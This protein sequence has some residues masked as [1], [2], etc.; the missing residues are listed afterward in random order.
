MKYHTTNNAP[1][2][3]TRGPMMTP[4]EKRLMLDASLP[5]LTGAVL[6][7]D[8]ADKTT[9]KDGDGDNAATGTGGANN[10]F[11]GSVATW[12]DKSGA[13][14]NLTNT[15]A[16][17]QPTYA[18][19]LNG[20]SVITFDGTND[21]LSNSG[22]VISGANYTTF[23]VFERTNTGTVRNAVYEL[24][25]TGTRNAIYYNN[26]ANKQSYYLNSIF[27]NY[28][29]NY[30][31]GNY[32]ILNISQSGTAYTGRVNGTL[33]L[34]GTG[35]TRATTTGIYLA[36]DS[37]GGDA[38]QGRVAE[39]IVYNR[40]LTADERHDVETYLAGKWGLT[41]PDTAPTVSTNTGATVNQGS[42]I[43]IG[44]ALLASTDIDNSESSLNYKITSLTTH[45]TLT[46]I[47]TAHTYTLGESFTQADIDAGYIKYTHD[48][49]TNFTDSFTFTV[50]D[51]YLSTTSNTFSFTVTPSNHA[52]QFQGWTLVSSENFESGAT[53]WSNTLTE[54]GGT[55]LTNFLGRHSQEAGV[56]S[57]YKTYTM[58]GTQDYTVITF[59]MYKIDSWDGESFKIFVND[60]VVFN[61]ALNQSTFA[62]PVDGVSGAV[63]YTV[64]DTTPY[65]ANFAFASYNDQI[66]HFTLTISNAAAANLKLG[67]S[68]T[69]DQAT[70][71]ESWGVDNINIYEVKTGGSPGPYSIVE[72]AP[73]G[74]VV[75]A[76]TAKDQDVGDVL[77]YS[78]VGGTGVGVFNLNSS[79]GVITVANSSAL[80][81]ES[82]TSYTLDIKVTDNGTPAMSSTKTI[83][84]NVTDMPENTAPTIAALGPLTVAENAANNTVIGTAIGSD[85]DGNTITYSITG[86]NTDN[87]FA[88]NAA[89][90]A[91]RISSNT[92]LNYDF[93]N[94]YTLTI[95]ATD[96]GFGSLV[97]TRNVVVNITDVNEAPTFNIPQSFLDQNPYLR[98]N[99]ATGNFYQY[100]ATT[101][102]YTAAT[103]AAAAATLNGVAGHL[104]TITSA[105]ENAYVRALGSGVLWLGGSDS[106]TEGIWIWA[107][108]GVEGG[109]VFSNVSTSQ[110]GYYT[111]WAAGQP[112]NSSNEDHLEMSAA[113]TWND[114]LL[115]VAKSYVIEWE[116]AAVMAALG[117]GP[118]T[119]AE[120]PVL[121]Q[122]V[123]SVHARDQDAGDTLTYSITGG[124]GSSYFAIDSSTGEITVTNP[125]ALDYET[126]TSYTL[127]T[128]VQDAGGLFSTQSVTIN[129]TD[130]NEA[131]VLDVNAGITL[132]EGASKVITNTMLSSSDVDASPDSALI[133]TVTDATD[134][135]I[136]FNTNTNA[137][138]ALNSTF[139]QGDVDNGY[140]RYIHNDGETTSDSFQFTVSDGLITL[141]SATFSII[142]TPVN[143]GPSFD[144]IQ[145]LL[146]A[147]A[148]LHYNAATGNFYKYVPFSTDYA[149]ATANANAMAL[150]GVGGYLA[151][152]NSA[153]E[154]A[155]LMSLIGGSVWLG[156]SDSDVE[157]TWVY[158]GGAEDGT[159][160][161]QGTSGGSA[162]N[163]N[164]TNWTAGEPNDYS[165]SEDSVQLLGNGEWN[166]INAGANSP[167]IVEWD[168]ASVLAGTTNGPYTINESSAINATVGTVLAYDYDVGDHLTYSIMGGSGAGV[169]S[170]NASTGEI[171]LVSPVNYEV[172][173][174]YTLDLRVQDS[175]GLFDTISIIIDINDVNDAPDNLLL[176]GPHN[177]TE[178][179]AIG[180]SVGFLT[181][182]DEDPAD[183]H[184]YTI[185]TN[186]GGKFMLVGDELQTAAAIDYEQNQSFTIVIRTDDGHGGTLDKSFI[187][188]VNDEPD[189]A[190]SPPT[191]NPNGSVNTYIAPEKESAPDINTITASFRNN[192]DEFSNFYSQQIL[193]ENLTFKLRDILQS[194]E[195]IDHRLE[196]DIEN[197]LM[198]RMFVTDSYLDTP[199]DIS[200]NRSSFTNLR[201]ALSF[202][203]QVADS[204]D[205]THDKVDE[206]HKAR[207]AALPM[208]TIDR[209]FVDVMTYHQER[210]AKL[211]AALMRK[212]G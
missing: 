142:V 181:T 159:A 73:N 156:G 131:P 163:G 183:T 89:T 161:W 70:S 169:F 63:S 199:Q 144:A 13:G 116:G 129:I 48:N 75:G 2:P 189:T 94:T 151:H 202:L 111:N 121:N 108:D 28:T 101:A 185:V 184:I 60:S 195:Q 180:T 57:T 211:R 135:G 6:W 81:Y 179:V 10:G 103:T 206:T 190:T 105:A 203:Q 42:N 210:A 14:N 95:A 148:S 84:I 147:D 191:A 77:A 118:F 152:S 68:S 41:V 127:T 76:I 64:T 16:S 193:R 132:N 97:G 188:N 61:V 11:S 37:T 3:K 212:E 25:G 126:A 165:S 50:N 51:A 174:S 9:V 62:S 30:V 170:V 46:N 69:L 31:P 149:T 8:A 133:Y 187:I 175:G 106:V 54:N 32:E 12:V 153:A 83:T 130:V 93:R 44:S 4:L 18:N 27:Y 204:A 117:N 78:I 120:N 166:D 49:S 141:P 109:A 21:V 98:Y 86:G 194:G 146:N 168:G 34:S 56:Q 209:Q 136:L 80:N 139:T 38:M 91:I 100:V 53:G 171:K 172:I 150:N 90:G 145:A 112:D 119:I 154:N 19:T 85:V 122:V 40:V 110:N 158:V 128:R 96:N 178:N 115:T 137:S 201:E 138:L 186:P 192:D 102:N 20:N 157:G 198:D 207:L 66:M 177:V 1:G 79:T 197:Y 59:D 99:A 208:S 87:I 143:E 182:H 173:N 155:F 124:T 134:N 88:I 33:D 17:Q 22:A 125:A 55:Y 164:Y 5:V 176:S 162:Q 104:A 74:K 160:F 58:T 43:T 47:N 200:G 52:P 205:G 39:F 92:N 65:L 26:T 140:I 196:E 167:Y 36:D 23:I 15:T 113:G 29:T 67:F 45:G 114:A 71:D 7:L 82:V 24:G 72:N 107:G 35:A 123:G